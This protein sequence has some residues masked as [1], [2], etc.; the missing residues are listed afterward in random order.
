M[1]KGKPKPPPT[2]TSTVRIIDPVTRIEGHLRISVTL[3]PDATGKLVVSDAQ[4]TGT[5]FR[6]FENILVGR[7]PWDA[8]HI[9]QRICGV[10]PVSHGMAAVLALDAAS[11]VTVPANA[12]IMRNLVMGANLID[13]HILH[14][15]HLTLPDYVT[16]PAMNMPPWNTDWVHDESFSDS[17]ANTLAAHYLEAL[18]ARRLAHEMGA[19]FGGKLPHPPA[20]VPGGFTTTPTAEKL[21]RFEAYLTQVIDFINNYYIPDV[22]FLVSRY[23]AY[24]AIGQGYGN[25]LAFGCFEEGNGSLFLKRGRLP[26]GSATVQ[27]VDVGKIA[28]FVKYSWYADATGGLTPA[29]GVTTPVD[30]DSKTTAYSWLKAPRYEGVPYEAGPLARMVVN[31]LYPAGK[32]SVNDRHLARAFEAL[33]VAEQM[34]LWLNQLRSGLGQPTY[35]RQA[36]PLNAAGV[37]LTE[38]PRGALGHWLEITNG[39]ISRYQVITPTCWN[40]SPR[41]ANGRRGPLEEALIGTPVAD[42]ERPV[43]VLRVVHS[44]DPCLACA[45]H[46]LRPE[47]GRKIFPVAHG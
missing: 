44:F 16:P 41:D 13:S 6:G 31:N 37:G 45:V 28:E 35:V 25:L 40:A 46:V 19:I 23:P 9:T 11:Q 1:P 47:A 24:D 3:T 2:P 30:P 18:K 39:K 36:V 27:A 21:S 7:H 33:E 38:A 20:Y 43:E 32:V 5:L 8:Q 12:R 42:P 4:S 29:A 15:Y 14:F 26:W 10:C 17:E 34:R 22:Q